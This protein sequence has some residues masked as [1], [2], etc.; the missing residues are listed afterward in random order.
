MNDN[1]RGPGET[2]A[3][4]FNRAIVSIARAICLVG[5]IIICGMAVMP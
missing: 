4:I 1:N 2:P 3:E 5:T